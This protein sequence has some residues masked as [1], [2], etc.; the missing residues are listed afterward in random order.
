MRLFVAVP[1]AEEAAERIASYCGELQAVAPRLRW[2]PRGNWHVTL[3]FLGATNDTR[4]PD[5]VSCLRSIRA[6]RF[7]LYIAGTGFFSRAGVFYCE[8]QETPPLNSLASAVDREMQRCGFKPEVNAYHPHITLARTRE[9]A[10]L[11][12]LQSMLARKPQP[13]FGS[14]AATEFRL[15]ESLTRP[16]GAHYEVRERFPLDE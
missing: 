12:R 11:R 2:Q 15:Y 8:V 5:V 13:D 3:K 7:D 14:F 10:P 1:I 6:R 16:G 9:P 4:L